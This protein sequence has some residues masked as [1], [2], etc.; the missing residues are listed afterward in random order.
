MK[1]LAMNKG[2]GPRT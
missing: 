1:T 2:S